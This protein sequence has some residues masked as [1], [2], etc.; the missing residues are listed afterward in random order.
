MDSAAYLD[1]LQALL[2]PGDAIATEANSVWSDVL[3]VIARELARLDL[4]VDD[5]LRESDPRAT[6]E[7]LVEWETETG[8]PDSCTGPIAD[9]EGRRLAVVQRLTTRG[10]QSAAYFISV[11]AQLGYAGATVEEYRPMHCQDPCDASLE[12]VAD[13][14]TWTLRVGTDGGYRI[15]TAE[16]AADDALATWG[17]QALECMIKRLRP[18]HTSVLFAY[19]A[20]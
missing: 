17:D 11:A 9:F 4:R 2:P 12:S 16:S 6:A 1:Q 14:Y 15:M 3:L 10:G 18:A 19:G 13:L 8:L 20:A 7:L 5:L